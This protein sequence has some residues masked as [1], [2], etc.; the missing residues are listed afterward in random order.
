MNKI[1]QYLNEHILGEATSA[2]S[3]R[4]QFSRDASFLSIMPE[5]VVHPRVTNDIRKVAR[6]TWQLAEKGHVMPITVRG[7]GSDQTG[8][9]IGKGIIIN[10]NAHLNNIIYLS[11]KNKDQFVHVQPG[12]IFGNVNEVLKSHGLIIP[13]FPTSFPYSTVGGAVANN[14]GGPLSGRYGLV[15]D[16][17]MR[18]E[19]VLANGDLVE[20]R[21]LNRHELD[22]KKGLQTFEGEIYR[23]I[24]GLIE[25]NSQ[26]IDE[27]ITSD[28]PDNTGYSG[29]AKV[30]ER[31]GSFDLTPLFIGSQGTLGIISEVILRSSYYSSAESIILAAFDKPE[32]A[33][34]AADT[35]SA[36][37]PDSLEMIDGR[38]F[39][40]AQNDYGKKFMFSNIEN[41]TDD[42]AIVVIGFNDFSDGARNHKVK[43][44]LKKLSKFDT[45]I[46]T[47]KDYSLDELHAVRGVSSLTLQPDAE[48]ESLPPLID[49]ATIPALRREEFLTALADL[50]EKHHIE[51]P[52]HVD[53]ISGVIH[54]RPVLQLHL[55][56]DKQKVF[57]LISD[58]AELVAK[59]GGKFNAESAEGRTKASATYSQL[60]EKVIEL[61]GQIRLAF[62]PFGTLNPG[63]KQ[64]SDLKTLVSD[65]NSDYNLA[66]FA[67]YSPKF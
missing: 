64:N 8:A 11:L 60:D 36:L 29:I 57:K 35:L 16:W 14:A 48:A 44:T 53:W 33:R 3:V 45:K 27:K 59:S 19:V 1:A 21:R 43:Q 52:T 61:Y 49:G 7:G 54:T 32:V 55:V 31:D 24:D 56:S 26:L 23:K 65:M 10:T 40:R 22:K 12:A 46:F 51:L 6:F 67:K 17:V 13:S 20:T 9:A 30:K 5:L 25:D 41:G 63:V 58:Y 39:A 47:D 15:G 66:D 50:A 62:D 34:D 18:L 28:M 2:K 37:K 4:Q 38:I 42:G